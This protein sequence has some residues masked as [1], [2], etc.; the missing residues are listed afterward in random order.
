MLYIGCHLSAS[1]GFLAMGKQA[2]SIGANTFQFFT[3]N[4]RGGKAKDLDMED[5][6]AYLEFAKEKGYVVTLLNR[7]RYIPELKSPV[8][9]Q[10]E[11][12]K[13]TA[14]N[15]PIQGSAA[16]IVKQAMID[17]DSALKTI[18]NGTKLILQVHDELI[19]NVKYFLIA[20]GIAFVVAI[21]S[22]LISC[23]ET[24][25]EIPVALLKAKQEKDA[26]NSL[27]EKVPFIWNKLSL[28]TKISI[29]N[30]FRYKT[31]MLMTVI[32]IGGCLA[33]MLTGLS[34]RTSITEMIP[35]QYGKIFKV[36]AQIFYNEISTRETLEEGTK[37]IMELENVKD[38]MLT[39]FQTFTSDVNGGSLSI[40]LVTFIEEGSFDFF[41]ELKQ[42]NS[43]PKWYNYFFIN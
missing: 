34:L 33:L 27:F 28:T 6:A 19:F 32:G 4:P 42:V 13:R 22:T 14:M 43:D 15:A 12:G 41:K 21:A 7:R 11:F 30:I 16:D 2:H 3:R 36:D 26:T 25:K 8:Y 31:R 35:T 10:R 17:I 39:N 38:G 23:K 40:N 18:N 5:V 29:K 20:S 37:K 9:M 24:F 1:K